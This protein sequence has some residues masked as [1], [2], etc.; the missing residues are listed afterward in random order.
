MYFEVTVSMVGDHGMGRSL[1]SKTCRGR[2][3]EHT[4]H[5]GW[6]VGDAL[7]DMS[8]SRDIA[9][10][11]LILEPGLSRGHYLADEAEPIRRMVAAATELLKWHEKRDDEMRAVGIKPH[12]DNPEVLDA[13][14]VSTS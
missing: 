1:Q 7:R 14:H 13:E 6:L 3:Q 9:Q 2:D 8:S 12:Y 4:D 5:L 11:V 10:I